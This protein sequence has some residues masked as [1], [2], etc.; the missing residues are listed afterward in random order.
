MIARATHWWQP[1]TLAARLSL[2]LCAGLLLAHALSFGFLFYE[3]YVYAR[4]MLMTNVEHDVIVAV[5]TLDR[6]RPEDRAAILPILHRRTV[7]YTLGPGEQGVALTDPMAREMVMRIERGLEAKYPFEAHKVGPQQMQVHVRLSDGT[8]LTIDLTPSVAPIA[9]WLPWV[10]AVQVVLLLVC[11]WLAVR[12]ATRPLKQLADAADRL[13]PTGE[14]ARLPPGGST[15]VDKAASAF[16]AMQ[17]RIAQY[18]KERVQILAAISHDLQT[19]ITRMRLRAEALDDATTREKM[20][21]DLVQMQHLVREGIAY[22][23]SAHGAA[24]PRQ[25]VD[26]DAFLDSFTCDYRDSGKSL[27]LAGNTGLHIET[28]V[29]ALRRLLANLVDNALKYAGPAVLHADVEADAVLL[30]V[31]DRGPGIPEAEL[32][33]V[34]HPFYRLESSRNRDTGG[35]GLGLAIAQELAA[36]LGATLVLRNREGGGLEATVRLPTND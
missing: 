12:I 16:N 23:R 27:T 29:H 34:L 9:D 5:N 21:E 32:A 1:K 11:A 14:G 2:I 22:A 20:T 17:D 4:S 33:N 31:A 19:P 7:T 24:E 3:R 36:S 13:S 6:L 10:L 28:R 8:P 35:T 30:R 18:V 26:L 25:R 15:E